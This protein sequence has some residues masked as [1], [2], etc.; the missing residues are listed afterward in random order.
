MAPSAASTDGSAPVVTDEAAPVAQAP[1]ENAE[2]A[3]NAAKPARG[4]IA[5]LL[6]SLK[7]A[8]TQGKAIAD[9]PDAPEQAA[10]IA[11]DTPPLANA[12]ETPAPAPAATPTTPPAAAAVPASAAKPAQAPVETAA[13]IVTAEAA[14]VSAPRSGKPTE[15]KEAK[16][17]VA[18]NA[19]ATAR[20]AEMPSRDVEV[21]ARPTDAAPASVIAD[22]AQP[23]PVA[24]TPAIAVAAPV[25][26]PAAAGV[27]SGAAAA[28]PAVDGAALAPADQTQVTVDRHLDLARD[29]QWLDRLARDISQAATREGHLKFHLNPEHL[30]ALT[31]EIAN[32]AAGTAIKLTTETDQART[33]IADAQ[34][35]LLAEVRAQGLRVSETHVELN[36]QQQGSGNGSGSTQAQAQNQQGQPGQQRQPSADSQPFGRRQ[37]ASRDDAGDS[38][39]QDNGELYA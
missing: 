30:G 27:Q 23:A 3:A 26:D 37:A 22:A 19:D 38:A 39:P 36:N 1:A 6:A 15:A 17:A 29:T 24:D 10:P 35:Q 9:A 2:A 13:P 28:N 7:S 4:N 18:L 20:V 32:S 11:I 34:P 14:M 5:T 31:V 8:F 21:P 33:I 16:A 12:V 25:I